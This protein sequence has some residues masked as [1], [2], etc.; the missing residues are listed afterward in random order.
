MSSPNR[1]Y[2]KWTPED[3]KKLKSLYC[4]LTSD[5]SIAEIMGRTVNSIV[6]RRKK[7]RLLHYGEWI[8]LTESQVNAISTALHSGWSWDRISQKL[9]IDQMTLKIAWNRHRAPARRA[10]A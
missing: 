3:D 7:L 10:R 9:G 8:K 6:T 4:Q 1:H 5:K 2:A